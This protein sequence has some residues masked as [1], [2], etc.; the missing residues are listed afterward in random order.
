MRKLNYKNLENLPEWQFLR[1]K[2]GDVLKD[3]LDELLA[4]AGRGESAKVAELAGRITAL[5][6]VL[7]MPEHYMPE[8]REGE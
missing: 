4:E 2:I 8:P 1:S 6:E 7:T 3:H 5:R